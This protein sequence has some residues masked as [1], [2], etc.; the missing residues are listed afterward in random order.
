MSRD[1]ETRTGAGSRSGGGGGSVCDYNQE[2]KR[3]AREAS[4]TPTDRGDGGRRMCG[5]GVGGGEERMMDAVG[6]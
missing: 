3:D 2:P 5:D 1:G 4:N 6:V